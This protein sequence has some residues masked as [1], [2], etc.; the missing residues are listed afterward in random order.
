MCM[1]VVV[2]NKFIFLVEVCIRKVN[3]RFV[4]DILHQSMNGVDF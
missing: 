1:E 2:K 4:D 3:S